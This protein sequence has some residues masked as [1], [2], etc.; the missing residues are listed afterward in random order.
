MMMMMMISGRI[1][2]AHTKH[3]ELVEL[4]HSETP[5]KNTLENQQLASETDHGWKSTF[6]LIFVRGKLLN[7]RG[8]PPCM[9]VMV[10]LTTYHH[11]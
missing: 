4:G 1:G 10:T 7:F 9:R 2:G 6:P 8:V 3:S 5:D 11:H